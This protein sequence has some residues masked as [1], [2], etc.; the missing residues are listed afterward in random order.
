MIIKERLSSSLNVPKFNIDDEIKP[1]V[2]LKQLYNM[3][4]DS[5][6]FKKEPCLQRLFRCGLCRRKPFKFGG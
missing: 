3:T 4:D 1:R 2:E 6:E 5:D